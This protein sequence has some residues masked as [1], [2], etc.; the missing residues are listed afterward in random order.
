MKYLLTLALLCAPCAALQVPAVGYGTSAAEVWHFNENTGSVVKDTLSLLPGSVVSAAWVT[1]KFGSGIRTVSVPSNSYVTIPN[2]NNKFTIAVN[3]KWT[4][5]LW[6]EVT[7]MY[8]SDSAGGW[9]FEHGGLNDGKCNLHAI[10]STLTY[11][12]YFSAYGY[13][14]N[15]ANKVP[16]TTGWVLFVMA[17]PGSGGRGKLYM[18]GVYKGA[19]NAQVTNCNPSGTVGIKLGANNSWGSGGSG[20]LYDDLFFYDNVELTQGQ[21]K[22]IYLDGLGRHVWRD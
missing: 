18:N 17:Y 21:I 4:L 5:G 10:K 6:I 3:K 12:F 15:Q 16:L 19:L 9:M 20:S 7:G 1:G 8:G 14:N 2:A 13:E 11:D 22:Q